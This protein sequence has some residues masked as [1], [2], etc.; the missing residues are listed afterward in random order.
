[1][2]IE[3]SSDE[4]DFLTHQL[5]VAS[6]SDRIRKKR[7]NSRIIGPLI[8]LALGLFY[9]FENLI[10]L[11]V[12]LFLLA[13]LWYF[14]Y[15]LWERRYYIRHYR[16]FIRE[17]YK[18]RIGKTGTLEIKDEFLLGKSGGSESR[19]LTSELEEIDEIPTLILIRLKGGQSFL[20]PK[21]KIP[22]ID[23]VKARLKELA[24]FVKINY[25]TDDKWE[26]K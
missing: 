17:N 15:P 20:L 5:F 12:I 16:D 10:I 22:N 4:N 26:W 23:G 9:I 11:A 18:E 2:I 13:V 8:Y 1:M 7:R 19:V 14:I 24:S 21:D 25:N 6:K 3:Y